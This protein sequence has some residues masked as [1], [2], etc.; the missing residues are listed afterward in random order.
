M[1]QYGCV[2]AADQELILNAV[3][4]QEFLNRA[5]EIRTKLAS[6]CHISLGGPPCGSEFVMSY[7]RNHPGG[8]VRN[9]WFVFSTLCF[10][11]GYN[12]S[13]MTVSILILSVLCDER[14][15]NDQTDRE[16][17]GDLPLH[18]KES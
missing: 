10:V 14:A 15:V 8:D 13:S 5:N 18:P 9:V 11:S 17:K 2:W 7:L 1:G 16:T 12:K 6:A 3:A 4:Y